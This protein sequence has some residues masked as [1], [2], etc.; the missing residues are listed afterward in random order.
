MRWIPIVL[1]VFSS[2]NLIS[3]LE[4]FV[5]ITAEDEMPSLYKD[6]ISYK[7]GRLTVEVQKLDIPLMLKYPKNSKITVSFDKECKIKFSDLEK[8][9]EINEGNETTQDS[10]VELILPT[11]SGSNG[12][13]A[14]KSDDYDEDNSLADVNLSYLKSDCNHEVKFSPNIVLLVPDTV[15]SR[16]VEPSGAPSRSH[17]I[18][19]FIF[20]TYIFAIS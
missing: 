12:E 7:D 13:C 5:A 10:Q 16:F 9:C 20:I 18:S 17:M 11:K 14:L 19:V 3:G 2:C 6:Y 1:V 4:E 15:I 8:S